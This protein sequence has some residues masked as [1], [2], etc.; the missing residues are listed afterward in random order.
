MPAGTTIAA[1]SSPPGTAPRAMVRLSGPGVRAWA[2][3]ACDLHLT[4]RGVHRARLRIDAAGTLPVLALFYPAPGSYTGQDILEILLPGSPFLSQRVLGAILSYEGIALAQPGEFS[5]RAYLSG[6][7][8]LAQAEGIALRIVAEHD[9]ALTAAAALLDGSYAD[10]CARW[11][12]ELATLLAL[13]EAGV[14]F[15]DQEDVIPI[16][17]RELHARL[18]S[19]RGDISDQL[20]AR[21]GDRVVSDLPSVVLM[22]EPNAGKSALFNALLGRARAAVSDRAGTTRDAITETLDLSRDAPGAGRVALTDL[23]GLGDRAIDAIDAQAQS[24]ARELIA[25]ADV[26]LWCDPSGRFDAS[27][28]PRPGATPVVRVRTKSDLPSIAGA[29]PHA[30]GAIAV[31]ALDGSAIAVLRRAIADASSRRT[32]TGVGVFVPRHRRALSDTAD[33]ITRALEHLDP[34]ARTL[35]EPELVALGLR[36]A[37]DA[38]GELVGEISPD[39]VIG[40]VFATFCV[41]K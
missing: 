5:A 36:E 26:V 4:G 38:A 13:V 14:D 8:S 29:P 28:W 32:G 10:R 35:D 19:L 9:E 39:E 25:G 24:R 15:S 34:D 37:L 18:G 11:S 40:R 23:A 2:L 31:C 6:R 17:P 3:D 30:P 33:G 7:L 1:I 41:G 20:G 27:S 21:A 12:D 22:G 16:E